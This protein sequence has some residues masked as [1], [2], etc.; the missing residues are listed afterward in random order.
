MADTA[1]LIRT[2]EKNGLSRGAADAIASAVEPVRATA[3]NVSIVKWSLGLFV[4]VWLASVLWLSNEIRENRGRIELLR[5]ETAEIR[6]ETAEMRGEMAEMR[7]EMAEMRGEMAEM[8]GENGER[9]ARIE[10]LLA[11]RLPP[12]TDQ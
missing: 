5:G 8:R 6:G 2:L 9:F 10:T 7:G 4:A 11:E 3:S 12:R 1:M